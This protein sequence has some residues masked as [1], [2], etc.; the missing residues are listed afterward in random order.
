MAIFNSYVANYQRV[1]FDN[2]CICGILSW[3]GVRWAFQTLALRALEAEMVTREFG[4]GMG[5]EVETYE[6]LVGDINGIYIYIIS[7]ISNR[8]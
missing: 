1:M 3:P 5:T 8:S 7:N 2:V 6:G 4:D